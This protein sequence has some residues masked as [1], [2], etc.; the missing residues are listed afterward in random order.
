VDA[1][2]SP[3]EVAIQIHPGSDPDQTRPSY[4]TSLESLFGSLRAA[5]LR[6]LDLAEPV[7]DRV[8]EG[9][10]ADAENVARTEI[11]LFMVLLCE[12]VRS[13]PKNRGTSR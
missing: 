9:G 13:R 3:R 10:R 1:Y 4:H 12:R 7:S 11:P 8:S 2:R 6:V 5:G